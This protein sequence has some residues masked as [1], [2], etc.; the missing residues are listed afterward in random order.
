MRIGELAAILQVSTK[1]LRHYERIGLLPKPLRAENGYRYY[2]E[3]VVKLA[4]KIIALRQLNLS[5]DTIRDLLQ[6]EPEDTMRERLLSIMDERRQEMS[7]EIAVMQGRQ[8]D[9]EARFLS[10]IQTPAS[11]SGKCICGLLQE[12]C[13]CD[14]EKG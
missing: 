10:L 8:E 12:S 6:A 2:P 4:Q 11:K 7:L 9:L 14:G 1:T 5:L 3:E 13:S